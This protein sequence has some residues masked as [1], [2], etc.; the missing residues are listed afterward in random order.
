M[1]D[2]V[3][4]IRSSE[5]AID[6]LLSRLTWMLDLQKSRLFGFCTMLRQRETS[7]MCAVSIILRN[8]RCSDGGGSW[9]AWRSLMPSAYERCSEQTPS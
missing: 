4:D 2:I 7:A 8:K 6:D 1:V 3:A 9:G 5:Y